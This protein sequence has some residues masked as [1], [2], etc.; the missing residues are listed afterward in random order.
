MKLFTKISL[1]IA[2]VAAGVGILAVVIGLAMGAKVEDLGN[3]GIYVSPNKHSHSF[4][5]IK[6]LEVDMQNA[7][8]TIF[9]TENTEEIFYDSNKEKLIAKVEGSVLKLED[10]SS[11][12]DNVELKLYIPVGILKEIDIEAVNGNLVADKIMADNVS[13]EMDNAAVQIDELIVTNQAELQMNAGQ[14]MVGYYEGKILDTECDM[15]SIM[16]VCSGKQSDYNYRLECSMGQIQIGK[17]SYSGMGNEL[18]LHNGSEKS[19]QAECALGEII[20]EFPNNL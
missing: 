18:K 12:Q 5:G 3:M 14:M 13:I 15:G 2:A 11:L 6:A 10:H 20:L 7:Q 9:A 4:Q 16:V 8:I 17:D 19:I 1:W